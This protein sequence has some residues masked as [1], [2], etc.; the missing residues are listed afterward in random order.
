MSPQRSRRPDPEFGPQVGIESQRPALAAATEGSWIVRCN[1]WSTVVFVVLA[2][3]ATI[4]PRPFTLAVI[5]VSL[6]MF[7]VGTIAFLWAYGLAI[8]RS[9]TEA[10]GM[11][12]LFFL[13]ASA[14]RRVQVLM[15]APWVVQIVAAFVAASVHIFT[16]IAFALLAPMLGL[17]LA[18]LWGGR[19]GSFP[20]RAT[21]PI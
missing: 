8:G 5:V 20:P 21:R 7:T 13:A 12:G 3:G 10:I 1:V 18:G 19:Y 15:M 11:G 9:R 14:P 6:A 16:G 2:I 17:G 4:W